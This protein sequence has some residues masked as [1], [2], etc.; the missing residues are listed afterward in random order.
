LITQRRLVVE[1]HV[2]RQKF[3]NAVENK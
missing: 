1:R 2:I 3:Q